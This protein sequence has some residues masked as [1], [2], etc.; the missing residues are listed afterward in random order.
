MGK[1]DGWVS[2]VDMSMSVIFSFQWTSSSSHHSLYLLF[3][4]KYGRQFCYSNSRSL[5][6]LCHPSPDESARRCSPCVAETWINANNG[7]V[8]CKIKS[9]S[10]WWRS[11]VPGK[12][13]QAGCSADGMQPQLS[14]LRTENG[15]SRLK[16]NE[17]SQ[18]GELSLTPCTSP[19]Y[20]VTA[21][22]VQWYYTTVTI[23]RNDWRD[24][25]SSACITHVLSSMMHV[26]SIFPVI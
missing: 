11:G 1:L 23:I 22:Q 19:L 4:N 16:S 14:L 2:H 8:G 25:S 26:F 24:I 15:T 7:H 18:P 21:I 12:P 5:P 17:G 6:Y 13:G 20:H 3:Y 10:V 9:G